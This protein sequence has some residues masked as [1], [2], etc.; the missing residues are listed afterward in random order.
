MLFNNEIV[1]RGTIDQT[2]R[3]GWIIAY[4]GCQ[5]F[6]G[7]E[8]AEADRH[9]GIDERIGRYRAGRLVAQQ[10]GIGAQSDDGA[11][12]REIEHRDDGSQGYRSRIDL[13]PLTSP[14]RDDQQDHASGAHLCRDGEDRILR[15]RE[16]PGEKRPDGPAE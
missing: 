6:T 1:A 8:H 2:E 16:I 14:K 12:N 3:S 15:L 4:P 5:D 11:E 13:R 7:E 9:D 10:I